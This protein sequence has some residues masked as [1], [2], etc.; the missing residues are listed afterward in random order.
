MAG[1]WLTIEA[2]VALEEMEATEIESK[3]VR[4]RLWMVWD[5]ECG[6]CSASAQWVRRKDR[7]GDFQIVTYQNC[8]RPPMTDEYF[9]MA[10]TRVLVFGRDGRMYPGADGVLFIL[11]NLKWGWLARVLRMPPFVWPLRL[12]YALV[13]RNRG[14][15]SQKFFGGV[16]CGMDN[17]YPE[18]E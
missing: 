5:G 18:V 12:G 7:K 11:E 3:I 13:A 2:K 17:R 1:A 14:W 10:K 9:E 4:N 8:P 6:L 16:A 15:I